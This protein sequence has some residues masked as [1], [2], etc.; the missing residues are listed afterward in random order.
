MNIVKYFIVFVLLFFIS[1]A[2]QAQR[3][4]IIRERSARQAFTQEKTKPR[5]QLRNHASQPNQLFTQVFT[6]G[7]FQGKHDLIKAVLKGDLELVRLLTTTNIDI[8]QE[9][10]N[11]FFSRRRRSCWTA[12]MYATHRNDLDIARLLAE[13]GADVNYENR[14]AITSLM[15]AA[16]N[17]NVASIEFL[18]E[19]G[20]KVNQKNKHGVTALLV[21]IIAGS[22]KAIKLL[23]EYNADVDVQNEHGTTALIMASIIG[24]IEAIRVLLSSGANVHLRDQNGWTALMYTFKVHPEI[25]KLLE[26]SGAE[27]TSE[28]QQKMSK[29]IFRKRNT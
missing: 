15:E 21:A 5:Q 28:D 10:R 29:G 22:I 4:P 8:N 17:N 19:S 6:H 9:D 1:E 20:A 16:G 14:N 18:V 26:E 27:M 13:S 11:I 3:N 23:I 12:L 25:V 2:S 24:D 7:E